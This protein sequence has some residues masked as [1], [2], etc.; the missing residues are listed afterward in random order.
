MKKYAFLLLILLPCF[1]AC[2]NQDEDT[3]EPV[4]GYYDPYDYDVPR[5]KVIFDTFTDYS[6]V[7]PSDYDPSYYFCLRFDGLI[8]DDPALSRYT[9][10]L[11]TVYERFGG[12]TPPVEIPAE[13]ILC[14]YATYT[15]VGV[16]FTFGPGQKYTVAIRDGMLGE[17][18]SFGEPYS[19]QFEIGP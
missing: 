14:H 5:I 11:V 16:R 15:E 18:G 8:E 9:T 10:E 2:E 13:V 1:F 17:N 12:V 7:I 6:G 3:P 4:T 19:V